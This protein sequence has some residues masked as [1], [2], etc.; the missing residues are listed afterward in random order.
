MDVEGT[1]QVLLLALA[2]VT[3]GAVGFAIAWV[4]AR[5]RVRHLE[6]QL[7][8]RALSGDA[9]SERVEQALEAMTLELER[10][11]EG[12]RFTTELLAGRNDP[13]RLRAAEPPRTDESR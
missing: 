9:G 6:Q 12:Q 1:A 7:A 10:L 5:D 2:V 3:S 13:A 11:A 8:G 4:R